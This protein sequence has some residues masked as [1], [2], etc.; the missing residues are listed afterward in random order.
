MEA[1]IA[2]KITIQ[3]TWYWHNTVSIFKV[4]QCSII[5]NIKKN[6]NPLNQSKSVSSDGLP[7]I[8]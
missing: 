4:Y 3:K 5:D 6:C 7:D 1:E 2:T 8:Q